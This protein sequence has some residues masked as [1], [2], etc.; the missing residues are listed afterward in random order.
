[1]CILKKD[2][3]WGEV[4]GNVYDDFSNRQQELLC[5]A[6]STVWTVNNKILSNFN[7]LKNR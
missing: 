3:F 1:M 7:D 5:I 2:T 6:S 4:V